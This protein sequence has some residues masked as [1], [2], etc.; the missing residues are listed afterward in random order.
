M[1]QA[2]TRVNPF[3]GLRSF[4][5]GEKYLFF[6]RDGL[7]DELFSRLKQHRF[8]AVVGP[9]GS[10]K[11][12]AVQAGLLPAIY[13]GHLQDGS[14]WR[15]VILRP[16][17]TPVRN[18]AV[19]LSRPSVLG[20]LL[21]S[22]DETMALA[23]SVE[24]TLKQG[25]EGLLQVIQQAQLQPN[26]K[27]LI[28]VDAFEE[29]FRI[30]DPST[31]AQGSTQ[32][33]TSNQSKRGGASE[34]AAFVSLLLAAVQQQ[35]YPA[36]VVLTMRSDF[37]GDCARF[38]GLAEAM[39]HSQF[40]VPRM[41]EAQQRAAISEPVG[42]VGGA[43]APR[44]IDRLLSDMGDTPDR[45]SILQH[46]LMRTWE[47]WQNNREPDEPVD[48]RHYEAIG[49]MSGALS[50]HADA[51][52]EQLT[53]RQ[54]EIARLLFQRLT[55]RGQDGRSIR[56]PTSLFKISR[57]AEV[58]ESEVREVVNR[59]RDGGH[60]FLTPPPPH[61]LHRDT[62]LDISHESL[63]RTWGRLTDWIDREQESVRHYQQLVDRAARY[64]AGTEELLQDPEL[65]LALHW[66][67]T[68]RPT[69]AWSFRYVDGF[70]DA[71][72]FLQ[73][74]LDAK[75]QELA[76]HD[77]QDREREQLRLQRV[78]RARRIA[79][80]ATVLALGAIAATVL[81][82]FKAFEAN[83][84]RYQVERQL[85]RAEAERQEIALADGEI[86]E[87]ASSAEA[88]SS[89]APDGDLDTETT[90]ADLATAEEPLSPDEFMSV[91]E[92]MALDELLSSD[93]VSTAPAPPA[94]ALDSG[95]TDSTPEDAVAQSADNEP[96]G[97]S[98]SES[99]VSETGDDET[100]PV[101]TNRGRVTWQGGLAMR[102]QPNYGGSSIGGVPF[103]AIVTLLELSDN[104]AWQKI[105]LES[106]TEG[107]VKAGNIAALVDTDGDD[108]TIA[109][110]GSPDRDD[111]ATAPA[112]TP[113]ELAR[114]V[115]TVETSGTPSGRVTWPQGLAVRSAPS[116]DSTYV[117]GIPF[118]STATIL[119]RSDD[120]RWQ[121]VRQASTGLEGW[122]KAGN[123][124]V[125]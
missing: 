2:S 71:I 103:N 46:A 107:W 6:G 89:Q 22:Q 25:A 13:S 98:A 10:G 97:E 113:P 83:R 47:Y 60:S 73:E 110:S 55:E 106:G 34:A 105:R 35:E 37:I 95:S 11:S 104:G 124:A 24:A 36:Y 114:R 50:Q 94:I 117:G 20:D 56:R 77:R 1:V 4:E 42:V 39:N 48:V 62:V 75:E 70:E 76:E 31:Q 68:Q 14:H 121:R 80:G 61:P 115:P 116:L 108:S 45:L 7:A 63:M 102:T 99:A 100:S 109:D 78:E 74:S 19:G 32:A 72:A 51:V 67:Q 125:E 69:I 40:L 87:D 86:V 112:P 123:I 5:F 57:V 66:R 96:T 38:I 41:T 101:N 59:F 17:G 93:T 28:V 29:L 84:V 26:E 120:G 9:S 82:L 91:E 15:T 30:Q 27:V 43:I 119:E 79:F 118:D 54:K 8:V 52:F 58:S 122:V 3:P 92:L 21:E 16:G 90:Q 64:R 53:V 33:R 85:Q 111:Q 18:L 44:L 23:M 88:E 12:S 65:S 81:A 49:T